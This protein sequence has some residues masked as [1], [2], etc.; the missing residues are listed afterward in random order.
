MAY[1]MTVQTH[2]DTQTIT[3]YNIKPIQTA[4][5]AQYGIHYAKYTNTILFTYSFDSLITQ[6]VVR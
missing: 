5:N 4:E 1:F 6:V 3:I 2:R